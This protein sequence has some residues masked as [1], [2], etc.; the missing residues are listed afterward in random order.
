MAKLTKLQRSQR[1][2]SLLMNDWHKKS[3]TGK[4]RAYG[5]YHAD[6]IDNQKR[7]GRCL[8]KPE[9]KKLFSW[10]WSYEVL[11]KKVKHPSFR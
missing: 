5:N 9:R 4:N 8:T 3:N 11:D 10:W 1:A 2:H 6:C 7:L